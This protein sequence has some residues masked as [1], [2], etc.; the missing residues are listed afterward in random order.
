MSKSIFV[1]S[2]EVSGDRHASRLVSALKKKD[3]SLNFFGVGGHF[4]QKEGVEILSNSSG[5]GVFGFIEVLRYVPAYLRLLR[6]IKKSLI[7]RKPELAILIDAQGFNMKIAKEA[8]KLGIPVAYY[9]APQE[10]H[11]GTEKGGRTVVEATDLILSIFKPEYEFYKKLGGN[12]FQIGHP[13]LDLVKVE[14]TS[15]QLKKEMKISDDKKI[16]S[17]FPGSRYQEFN[18]LIPIFSKSA[19]SIKKEI[20]DIEIVMSSAAPQFD[21]FIRKKLKKFK[22]TEDIKLFNGNS[23]DLMGASHFAISAS[24]T[25]T[26]EQAMLGLPT[27]V[28][29]KLNSVS[30]WIA[31]ATIG[32]KWDEKIKYISLPNILLDRLVVT[33]YI[34][35]KATE[36][37]ITESALYY[38]KDK[39]RLE[40]YKSEIQTVKELLGNPGGVEQAANH[41]L[42]F[43][44][45]E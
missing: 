34:Q 23:Y 28:A 13:L 14:K 4:L 41:V 9:I 27:I 30:Y 1:C 25:A 29:G 43:M 11:W 16:L 21:D 40:K 7:E 22:C 2:A 10:W 24:G 17:I 15:Q 12:V 32:K 42:A 33:E 31:R 44:K 36:K 45:G 37:A 26:L 8:K 3:S 5:K 6:I 20:P 18:R 19:L 35:F 38:L 39:H